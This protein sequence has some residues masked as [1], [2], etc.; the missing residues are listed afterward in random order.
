MSPTTVRVWDKNGLVNSYRGSNG[1]RYFNEEDLQRLRRIAHLR[2][3]EKLNIEGIRRALSE[4]GSD[5]ESRSPASTRTTPASN[6]VEVG[7]R[8]RKLRQDAGMTL[9]QAAERAGLSP[10]F[11][12]AL[13]RDQTGVSAQSLHRLAHV[14]DTTVSAIMRRKTG[15]LVQLSSERKRASTSSAEG[16]S[17]QPLID[18]KNMLDAEV[19]VMEPDT[20]GGAF[21][22]EGEEI[23]YMLEGELD[24]RLATGQQFKLKSGDSLFY[25]TTIEHEWRNV[26]PKRARFL[27]VATPPTY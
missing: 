20:S 22:H 27:W 19:V 21:S 23:L 25:P 5:A 17:V 11:L 24:V 3:V 18:G 9:G 1:Y 26:G 12:S 10:S 4:A 2:Y 15:D 7:P 13:E 8:L 6:T 16:F 14:Y